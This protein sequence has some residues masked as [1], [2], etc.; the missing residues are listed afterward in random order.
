MKKK[1]GVTLIEL[2]VALAIFMICFVVFSQSFMVS[3]NSRKI[4][5]TKI[6]TMNYAQAIAEKYKSYANIA[7]LATNSGYYYYFDDI[8]SINLSSPSKSNVAE[9]IY[10]SPLD[11]KNYGAFVKIT[12]I[13]DSSAHFIY[14]TYI[15]VWDIKEHSRGQSKMDIIIYK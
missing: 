4:G 12:S 8:N 5:N 1:K 2:I 11:V 15:N 14:K 7:N 13:S 9:N 3:L 6:K 10:E